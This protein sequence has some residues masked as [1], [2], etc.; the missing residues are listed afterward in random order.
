MNQ[1]TKQKRMR[2]IRNIAV[3]V[4]SVIMLI[5]GVG[6]VYVDVMLGQIIYHPL[7]EPSELPSVSL[8][9]IS[10]TSSGTES[11]ASEDPIL[12]ELGTLGG[13]YHDDAITN[14]LL[15]GVDDYQSN[16]VGRSDSMMLVSVDKRHEKLKVTSFMR[17]LYVAI[18]G[19][20]SNKLNAAYPLGYSK[21][22]PGGGGALAVST[23]EAN[24]GVDIDRFV[25]V[26]DS[27]FNEIIDNLGGVE[28][29]LTAAEA[30]LVNQYSGD[31]RRNLKAG[32]FNLSGKQAHYYSRIRA[33]GD[34]FERTERQ[35][36]VLAS[37]VDKF[38]T[39]DI[40][41]INNALYKCLGLVE[42]NMTKDEIL[43]LAANSLTYMNY[44]M[45]QHRVPGDTEYYNA[46]VAVGSVLVPDRKACSKSLAEFIF[47]D[48]L[49][50]KS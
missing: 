36:K 50:E 2:L 22:G 33:I 41:T 24:F 28:I 47:E 7:E 18:P 15:L 8:P 20:S 19:Y 37:L 23:I 44:E 13:L 12:G 48:D 45:Q 26:K 1:T 38:K 17:D 32:T 4:L 10:G 11:T 49:P 27:A 14:I 35:R 34:D 40:G 3:L 46:N 16:D 29:T 6:C 42:T 25:L 43:Y 21:N 5:G 39:A 9:E 30:R 31:S